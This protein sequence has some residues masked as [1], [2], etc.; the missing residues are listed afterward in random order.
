MKYKPWLLGEKAD[1]VNHFNG[2]N[3]SHSEFPGLAGSCLLPPGRVFSAG[4]QAAK[5]TIIG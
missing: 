3:W 1:L 4:T 2:K 5:G